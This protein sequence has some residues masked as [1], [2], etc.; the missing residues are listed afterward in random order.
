M[1]IKIDLFQE[2]DENHNHVYSYLLDTDNLPFME[3]G[4]LRQLGTENKLNYQCTVE[5]IGD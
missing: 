1:I 2:I 4:E 5:K 3:Q